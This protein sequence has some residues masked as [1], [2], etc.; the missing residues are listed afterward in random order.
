LRLRLRLRLRLQ[1]Q[2]RFL[3]LQ[4]PHRLPPER[5]G[6]LRRSGSRRVRLRSRRRPPLQ[7]AH[8]RSQVG[9]FAPEEQKSR[10]VIAPSGSS[11]TA[12]VAAAAAAAAA[13]AITIT[14]ITGIAARAL[15][16]HRRRKSRGAAPP[17]PPAVP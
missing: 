5:G 8:Q 13:A 16:S 17:R 2:R 9:I 1:Q 10:A 11:R 6:L 15:R 7:R 14:A 4:P 12:V 3:R